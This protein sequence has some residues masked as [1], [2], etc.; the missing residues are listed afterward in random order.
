[1]AHPNYSPQLLTQWAFA[2]VIQWLPEMPVTVQPGSH[3]L[4]AQARF[5]G[6]R[7]SV[8]TAFS[9]VGS[10]GTRRNG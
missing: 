8:D 2:Q 10:A 4:Q 9:L 5:D 6:V 3:V 7:A 1:M